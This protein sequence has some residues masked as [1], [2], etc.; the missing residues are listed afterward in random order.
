MKTIK[1]MLYN[2]IKFILNLHRK[3]I[4]LPGISMK[5]FGKSGN[6][7]EIFCREIN[8]SDILNLNARQD[9][10]GIYHTRS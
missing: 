2:I 7:Q 4:I 6:S 1:I 5:I 3:I 9:L 10:I 8:H